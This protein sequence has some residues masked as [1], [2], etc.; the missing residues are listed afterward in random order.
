MRDGLAG[1]TYS[2]IIVEQW[3]T[4][5]KESSTLILE[6]NTALLLECLR[7]HGL[8]QAEDQLQGNLSP[9]TWHSNKRLASVLLAQ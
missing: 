1:L 6:K 8:R 9:L 2:V 7:L 3:G 4:R 5:E